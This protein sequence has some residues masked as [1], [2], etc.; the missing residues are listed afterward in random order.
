[1]KV[2]VTGGHG[3]IGSALRKEKPE[4]VYVSSR[5]YDLTSDYQTRGMIRDHRHLDAIIH[6][7]GKVGGIK[8]N[9]EKQAEYIHK[10]IKINTNVIH[11]A[12][13]ENV[14]RVLSV[15]STC[16]FP[17]N[18]ESFPF[19]EV[20][21]FKGPPPESN[22]SYGYAKRCLHVMSS[23][24]RQQYGMDYSTF[25]PSNVY[26]PNDNF[27]SESS[28]FVPAMIKKFSES[29]HGDTLEFWGTGKPRRQQLYV[30]DLA[31]IIPLL[32]ENHNT[33]APVIVAPHENLSIREMINTC[34]KISKKDVKYNFN[35]ELEG[36]LRKDGKNDM[37]MRI[38]GNYNFTSFEEGLKKTYDWY[39]AKGK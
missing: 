18:I 14:P 23:A 26:G 1:M 8:D 7:A 12:Y 11:E 25:S 24:Y 33:S 21:L 36:Q 22:F 19:S 29:N 39:E 38:I 2:L 35:G 6:L 13:K 32:L 17:E 27:D 28:H 37:L 4:W 15:L 31:Q 3:F 10:N 5:D 34:L 16:V 9:I 30:E 20:D